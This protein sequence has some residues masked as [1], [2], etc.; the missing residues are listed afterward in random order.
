MTSTDNESSYPSVRVACEE[1]RVVAD[2]PAIYRLYELQGSTPQY[3][4]EIV[5]EGER[6]RAY[7]GEEYLFAMRIFRALVYGRVTPCTLRAIVAD[8]RQDGAI[9]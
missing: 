7:L 3:L 6:D 8:L 9:F 4:M 2:C 1:E 5:F